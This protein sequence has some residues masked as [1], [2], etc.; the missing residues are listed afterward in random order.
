MYAGSES[1][2]LP[3]I[4]HKRYRA[5]NGNEMSKSILSMLRSGLG[6]SIQKLR[7]L[8]VDGCGVNHVVRVATERELKDLYDRI[9]PV[10]AED[11]NNMYK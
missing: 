10:G 6:D 9:S 8:M 5:F 4:Y 3:P 2:V 1:F 7:Y 11:T